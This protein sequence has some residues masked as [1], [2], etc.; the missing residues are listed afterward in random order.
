M[1]GG[2]AM[3]WRGPVADVASGEI[4]QF[5]ENGVSRACSWQRKDETKE[6]HTV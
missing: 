1:P 2:R 5:T 6:T 3:G 4:L